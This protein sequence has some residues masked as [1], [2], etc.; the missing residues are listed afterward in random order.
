MHFPDISSFCPAS[1]WWF[2]DGQWAGYY[3]RELYPPNQCMSCPLVF[4]MYDVPT[5]LLLY[6]CALY[7]VVRF[8]SRNDGF[9]NSIGRIMYRREPFITTLPTFSVDFNI[10]I[11][12]YWIPHFGH[13]PSSC[14][15]FIFRWQVVLLQATVCLHLHICWYCADC[16]GDTDI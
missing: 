16:H 8:H 9:L 1:I 13:C 2:S 3:L 12:A 15:H 10:E 5:S 14:S 7:F 4:K 6:E 11:V